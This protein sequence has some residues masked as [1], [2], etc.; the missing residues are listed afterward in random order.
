[1]RLELTAKEEGFSMNF[2][3]LRIAVLICL[4]VV[5][6]SSGGGSTSTTSVVI[7]G[8]IKL[9]KTGQLNCYDSTG[10]TVSCGTPSANGQDGALQK[11]GAWPDPR[12]TN[13]DGTTPVSGSAVIDQLTGLMWTTDANAPGPAAC[14]PGVDKNWQAALDYIACLNTNAFLGYS[15]WRLPNRKEL[16]SLTHIGQSN[17]ISSLNTQGIAA[18]ASYYWSSTTSAYIPGA[19]WRVALYNGEVFGGTKTGTNCVW[20]V[21]TGQDRASTEV[22]KT[23]Q[24]TC[25]DS[26]GNQIACA[27]TRQDGELQKGVSWPNPRFTNP[28]GTSP[29]SGS[30][31]IDQLTGLMWPQN[32]DAP[33]PVACSPG[34]SK[35]WQT[36]LDYVACLNTNSYLGYSDWRLPNINELESLLNLEKANMPSWFNMQSFTNVQASYYWSSS[37]YAGYPAYAWFVSMVDGGVHYTS[38]ANTQ[39]VWPVR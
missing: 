5:S 37:T 26:S 27:D 29:V 16:W 20:P 9:P 36:A 14:G 21:R 4:L 34:S 31:V 13:A 7:S 18:Q 32:A 22:P 35:N 10:T 2:W 39:Y 38:K 15:D 1:M 6:C 30:V 12:F 8:A 23:G 25:S 24:T 33:G 11:G 3:Y 19:A 17:S 28:D